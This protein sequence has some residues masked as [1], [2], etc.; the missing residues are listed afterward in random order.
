MSGDTIGFSDTLTSEILVAKGEIGYPVSKIIS[1][2][3]NN[4]TFIYRECHSCVLIMF[5]NL[6]AAH[7]L[8]VGKEKTNMLNTYHSLSIFFSGNR[9]QY[10][11]L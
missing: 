7:S 4:F 1:N 2:E 10:L 6:S 11:S 8:S 5:A 9:L 3:L